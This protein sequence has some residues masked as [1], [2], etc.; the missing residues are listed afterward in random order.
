MAIEDLLPGGFEIV[1]E[2]VH[3]RTCSY[4]WGGIDYVDVREDRLLAFGDISRTDTMITYRIKATNIGTYT[5]PPPQ[6]EAMYN[7]K[8][9]ARGI[10]GTLTVQD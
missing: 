9:R 5:I 2:S 6:A 8:V 10:S 1:E 4:G 3:T 7:Q